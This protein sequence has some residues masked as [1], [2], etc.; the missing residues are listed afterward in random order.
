MRLASRGLRDMGEG[1]EAMAAVEREAVRAQARRIQL[2]SVA[3]GL[4]LAVLVWL[5]P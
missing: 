4:L 5:L 3:A 1:P 2:R